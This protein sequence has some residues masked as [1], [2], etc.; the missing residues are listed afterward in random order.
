MR[1][2]HH[3]GAPLAEYRASHPAD[4][5]GHTVRGI[6]YFAPRAARQECLTEPL[7]GASA[8]FAVRA[9]G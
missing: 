8:A 2:T 3:L 4:R 7:E 5:A 1:K 9:E 6:A